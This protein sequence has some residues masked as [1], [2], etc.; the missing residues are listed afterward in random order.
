[1][2]TDV[3]GDP[4]A[5]EDLCKLSS[6]GPMIKHAQAW[7]D[8][9]LEEKTKG[10]LK[11]IYSCVNCFFFEEL[12]EKVRNACQ[13]EMQ[14]LVDA[15]NKEKEE[16]VKEMQNLLDGANDAKN[17]AEKKLEGLTLFHVQ[18]SEIIDRLIKERENNEETI[19]GLRKEVE[20]L[21]EQN[22]KLL[23]KSCQTSAMILRQFKSLFEERNVKVELA[24]EMFKDFF[25][26]DE[27]ESILF[28]LRS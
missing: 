27:S 16:R 20:D 6:L 10:I 2:S 7:A 5:F 22:K 4:K 3:I 24:I 15:A 23:Q 19:D 17:K 26:T 13:D 8:Q 14:V 12:T 28:K 18:K 1:M 9:K 11:I 21:T 25:A